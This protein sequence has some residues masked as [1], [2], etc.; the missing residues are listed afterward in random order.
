MKTTFKI[1]PM[2]QSFISKYS[3]IKYNFSR[4]YNFQ[5]TT[6]INISDKIEVKKIMIS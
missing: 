5:D 3:L 6:N 1:E 4:Y 2:H